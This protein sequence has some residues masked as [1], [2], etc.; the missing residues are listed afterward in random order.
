MSHMSLTYTY[1]DPQAISFAN[2]CVKKVVFE[3]QDVLEDSCSVA[4]LKNLV[5]L[6]SALRMYVGTRMKELYW[7]VLPPSAATLNDIIVSPL[8]KHYK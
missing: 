2:Y 6:S 4:W 5:R 7:F 3:G 8:E 1:E